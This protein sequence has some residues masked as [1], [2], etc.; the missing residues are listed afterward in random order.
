M[1]GEIVPD[2]VE[3][4][5]AVLERWSLGDDAVDL[6]LTTGGTG[7]GPR[8][9]TPEATQGV[10]DRE[11]P[12]FVEKIRREGEAKA[13]MAALSR[14]VAGTRGRTLILNLPGSPQGA[15]E[16]LGFVA[17]LIDHAIAMIRG[18]GH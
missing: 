13:P 10:L 3:G 2:E 4:I 15:V 6:I 14:A 16:S 7:L 18:G 11:I 1:P 9:V 12:G 8:D 17:D 5:S